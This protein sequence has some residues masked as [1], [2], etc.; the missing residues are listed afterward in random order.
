M[1]RPG[2]KSGSARPDLRVDR[3]DAVAEVILAQAQK[4]GVYAI[5]RFQDKRETTVSVINGRTDQ[6]AADL[7]SGVGVQVFTPEGYSGFASTDELTAEAAAELVQR[8]AGLARASAAYGAEHSAINFAAAGVA[9][10]R[11]LPGQRYPFDYLELAEQEKRVLEI[12]RRVQDLNKRLSVRTIFQLVEEDWRVIRS[13]GTDTV[14]R[15]PRGFIYHLIVAREGKRTATVRTS[16]SGGGP[17]LLLDD[18]VQA[19]LSRRAASAVD[20]AVNLLAAPHIK[21]GHYKLVVD[22][23]LAKGLAHEAF[24]H[25]A[26]SD[27]METSILGQNGRFRTGDEVAAPT[28]SI[29]DGP[30]EGDYAYQPVSANGV[31]RRTVEIVSRGRLKAALA[32][33]FSAEKAGVAVTGAGRAEAYYHIPVPRMSNIRI[34]V[35]DPIPLNKDFEDATP[36]DLY[37][38]LRRY[39]LIQPGEEALYL[40]GYVG[41]QVNP[42]HGDFVFNCTGIYT[43]SERCVLHQPAI[44]SGKVLSALHAILAGIGPVHTDAMGTCGKAGQGVPSS[45]GAH[46]FLVIDRHNDITIGGE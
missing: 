27:A 9:K 14:F 22:Y 8:A 3:Y 45:G 26:E 28:V 37:A 12:N 1:E 4:E 15:M 13:D 7:A 33:L 25:A 30:L 32:D 40:T 41:G 20:L 21:S 29:I 6:M 42:R 17:E 10:D 44:F 18:A 46:A 5:G 24:G 36:E 43:L 19:R 39:H 31:P 35:E 2:E 16:V 23:A 34:Q 11:V 38:I